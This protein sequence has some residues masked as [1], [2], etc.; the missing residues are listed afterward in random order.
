M[1]FNRELDMGMVFLSY[2]GGII[3]AVV[4]ELIRIYLQKGTATNNL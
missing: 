1:V 2:A 3:S 4:P